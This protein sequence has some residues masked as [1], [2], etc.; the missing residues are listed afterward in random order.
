MIPG[1]AGQCVAFI[2]F[3]LVTAVLL[4]TLAPVAAEPDTTA[5]RRRGRTVVVKPTAG[6]T[7]INWDWDP[8][9]VEIHTGDTVRWANPTDTEHVLDPSPPEAIS[10]STAPAGFSTEPVTGTAASPG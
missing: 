2:V 7:P 6:A 8:G 1:G 3:G 4:L 5:K 9:E 10:P